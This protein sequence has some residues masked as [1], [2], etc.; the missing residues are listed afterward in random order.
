LNLT[1]DLSRKCW[2]PV[3]FSNAEETVSSLPSQKLPKSYARVQVIIYF[4]L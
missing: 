2:S 1:T 3:F 4:R